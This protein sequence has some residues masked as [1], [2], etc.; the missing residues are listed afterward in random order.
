MKK[1]KK[2]AG[3]IVAVIVLL[4]MLLLIPDFKSSGNMVQAGKRPYFWNSD[5]QWQQVEQ[6]FKN[7]K[8]L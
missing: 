1:I 8:L 4:Y 3:R 7:A 6:Q 2:I 5:A